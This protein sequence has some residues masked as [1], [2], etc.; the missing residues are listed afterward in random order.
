MQ[1]LATAVVDMA[2]T[3]LEGGNTVLNSLMTRGRAKALC[4]MQAR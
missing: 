1:A 3:W 2:S 4:S